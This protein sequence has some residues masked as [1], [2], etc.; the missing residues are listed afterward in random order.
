MATLT[1]GHTIVEQAKNISPGGKQMR[2]AEVLT[3]E[4]AI[5][6]DLK[7]MP[8]NDTWGHKTLEEASEDSAS[9]RGLDEYVASGAELTNENYDVIGILER[10]AEYDIE[11]IDN[12]PDPALAR[13][14]KARQK[15]RAMGRSLASTFLYSNHNVTPKKPHGLAPRLASTGRYVISNGGAATLTSIYVVTHGEGLVYGVFPKYSGDVPDEEFIIRHQDM[16]EQ[17]ITNS[18]G[19]KLRKYVDNFKFK[20]GIVVEDYRC[21][22]RVANIN[23]ATAASTSWEDNLIDL[24]ERMDITENTVIYM[25]E[26]MTGAARKRMKDKN[27][28]HWQ[29]G[30]GGGL[31]GAPVMKFDEIP[32][33]KIDSRIL[34]N[35]ESE[36]T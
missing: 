19:N 8:S 36:I 20:G 33:R 21:L 10:F 9:W 1:A 13:V 6:H 7:F 11:Y 27:N 29:P 24:I 32:V 17:L 35:S 15:L 22:G 4:A 34:L 2:I 30:Q 14:L 26:T 3:K 28:V 31:F 5:L 16:G 12:Q 18:S 23:S 25:N